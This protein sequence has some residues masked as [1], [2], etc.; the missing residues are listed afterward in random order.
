[1]AYLKSEESGTGIKKSAPARVK[2]GAGKE[3]IM[4][5]EIAIELYHIHGKST[6]PLSLKNEQ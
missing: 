4:P 6:I 5:E 1:M 3:M 2:A